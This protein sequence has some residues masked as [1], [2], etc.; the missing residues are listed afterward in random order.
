MLKTDNL[1]KS[2]TT[3]ALLIDL[4]KNENVVVIKYLFNKILTMT[5]IMY[6]PDL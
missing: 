3:F 1:I 4:V 5:F 6:Y 2:N